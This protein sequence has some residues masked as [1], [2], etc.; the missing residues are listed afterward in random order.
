MQAKAGD[1]SM[2]QSVTPLVFTDVGIWGYACYDWRRFTAC[3]NGRRKEKKKKKM[4]ILQFSK[5]H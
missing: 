1:D 3:L 2:Q 4:I 5:N